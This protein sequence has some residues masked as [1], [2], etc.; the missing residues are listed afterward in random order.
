M[1][2]R[3]ATPADVFNENIPG[4]CCYAG[5]W[6]GVIVRRVVRG[7]IHFY[8][9]YRERLPISSFC[10]SGHALTPSGCY[11]RYHETVDGTHC[12]HSL[13]TDGP[14]HCPIVARVSSYALHVCLVL[15]TLGMIH[16][17]ILHGQGHLYRTNSVR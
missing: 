16:R 12:H 3:R 10:M 1:C 11:G 13:P 15:G 4:G 17:D 14:L 9:Y 8:K 2:F 7:G 6:R 5:S